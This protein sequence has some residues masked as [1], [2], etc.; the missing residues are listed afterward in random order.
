MR[1][2]MRPEEASQELDAVFVDLGGATIFPLHLLLLEDGQPHPDDFVCQAL[3]VAIDSNS[4]K[5]GEGRDGV[6][7]VVWALT[8]PAIS[9]ARGSFEALVACCSTGTSEPWRRAGSRAGCS[10]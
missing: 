3:G 5:G 8:M 10:T 2:T 6:A 7:A 4:G 1:A 9:V